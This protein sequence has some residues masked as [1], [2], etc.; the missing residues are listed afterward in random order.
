MTMKKEREKKR[1]RKRKRDRW[2]GWWTGNGR[3]RREEKE[4]VNERME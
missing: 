4:L 3:E 1:N 2:N